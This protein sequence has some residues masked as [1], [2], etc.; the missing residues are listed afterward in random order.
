MYKDSQEKVE[1]EIT[2]SIRAIR[3]IEYTVI[4]RLIAGNII[5]VESEKDELKKMLDVKSGI[6]YFREDEHGLQ[7]IASRVQFVYKY[8]TFT[9]RTERESGNTT[10]LEKRLYA[11][12]HGYL[13]PEFT[14]QAYFDNSINLK[15]YSIA[16]IKT[17]DLFEYYRIHHEEFRENESNAKFKYIEWE[18]LKEKNLNIKIY[19][20]ADKNNYI[21]IPF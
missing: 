13:Y 4:P 16:I 21:D 7:G 10:E 8:N 1:K 9:I 3:S 18:R 15:I 12:E 6:D 14:L 2:D 11:I 5:E 19:F 20:E 17:I